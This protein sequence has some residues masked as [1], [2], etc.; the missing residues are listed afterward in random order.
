MRKDLETDTINNV[1]RVLDTVFNELTQEEFN[2]TH[3]FFPSAPKLLINDECVSDQQEKTTQSTIDSSYEAMSE[4]SSIDLAMYYNLKGT[5]YDLVKSQ[6]GSRFLQRVY[7]QTEQSILEKIFNELCPHIASLMI[8][9]YANYFCQKYFSVLNYDTKLKFLNALTADIDIISCSKVGTYPLQSV[10]EQLSSDEMQI[11]LLNS[12]SGKILKLCN[13]FQ[14][15]HVI[16]KIIVCF[17]E[18]LLEEI[19]SVIIS[20]FLSLSTNSIGLFVCKK[21]ISSTKMLYHLI[22]IRDMICA[23]SM[24]LIHNQYGNYTIQVAIESWPIELCQPLIR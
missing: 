4:K 12:L 16:E 15:V 19:Y 23:N 11:I 1:E 18:N 24:M 2:F 22:Q 17:K 21:I 6:N 13:D 9:P 3:E 20:N 14:G 8:D 7:I 10:I 5:F